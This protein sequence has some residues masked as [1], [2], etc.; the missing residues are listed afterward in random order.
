MKIVIDARPAMLQKTGI[1]HYTYNLA[2]RFVDLAPEHDYYLCDVFAGMGFYN[3]FPMSKNLSRADLFLDLF[4]IPF[5]FVTLSRLLLLVWSKLRGEATQIE[6]TD[7]FFGTNFRG[8]FRDHLKTV[9]TIHD[10]AHEYFPDT[11]KD[12]ETYSYLKIELPEAA[13]KAHKIIAVSETT[14]SD[15][16]RF[17]GINP[18]KIRVV[19]NGVDTSFQ[20]IP[21]LALRSKVREKYSLP[22]RFFLYVGAI[23]PRKNINGLV[24]AYAKIRAKG[25]VSHDLVIAGADSWKSE[26]LKDRIGA[27]GLQGKV[28]FPGYVSDE[29]LPLL[30]NLAD[31]F[32]FPSLYEGFGLPVLE[33]MACGTPVVTSKTSSLSEIAGAAALLVDPDA[34]DEIAGAM[35]RLMEDS[36]LR[37]SCIERGLARAKLFTWDSCAR[38]TLALLL[39]A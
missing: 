17:L 27:L 31:V 18:D 22:P 32:V 19:Y 11:I 28:H 9:I 6:E 35:E 38:E 26:G 4:K 25:L 13:R 39:E 10:M 15:I 30:Y 29:D 33:A 20:Q 2:K 21:D 8:V 3:M 16:I 14:R 36:D 23:Q 5:P 1:G 34:I 37:N 24:E 7:I 12:A